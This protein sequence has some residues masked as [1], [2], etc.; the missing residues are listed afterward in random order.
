MSKHY[1]G[2]FSFYFA[3]HRVKLCNTNYFQIG[4][5]EMLSFVN[6]MY[7]GRKCKKGCNKI[8]YNYLNHYQSVKSDMPAWL[9][10]VT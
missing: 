3:V 7:V 1:F 10:H 4:L 5:V 9:C 2:Y 6:Y 8:I